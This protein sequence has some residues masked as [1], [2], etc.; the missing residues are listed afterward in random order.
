VE[1][2]NHIVKNANGQRLFAIFTFRHEFEFTWKNS[3]SL[4]DMRLGGLDRHESAQ[5]IESVFGQ[6]S[7][8]RKI[9]RTLIKQSDGVP[10]YLEEC[11]W[12]VLNQIQGTNSAA[13]MN[14]SFTVPDTLQDSLNA[15]LDMLGPARELAQLASV[16]GTY[17]TYSSIE[18]ISNLNGIDADSSMDT[19]LQAG[20]L[21]AVLQKDEDR[22]EFRH[23]M[24][25]DAAYQSLLKKTRQRYH[26]QIAEMFLADDP[27]INNRHP[28][29]IAFHYSCTEH[30]DTAVDLWIQAGKVAISNSTVREAISHLDQGIHLLKQLSPSPRTKEQELKLL[31]NL[32]V[33][34]TIQSGY[35]GNHITQ[36]YKRCSELA[37]EIGNGEQQWRALYGFWRCL[38]CLAEFASALRIS[39]KLKALCNFLDNRKLHMATLGIQAM[40]RMFSGRFSSAEKF[41][42][43]SVIHYDEVEDRNIGIRFGQDPYV[44][45]EGMGAVNK[46]IRGHKVPSR[47]RLEKSVQVARRIGHPY[48]I[49]EALRLAAVYEQ[50]SGDMDQLK[51]IAEEAIE[52]SEKFGFEGLLAASNIFLAFSDIANSR[53]PHAIPKIIENLDRYRE[54]YALLFYPYF[55]GLLA[56]SYLN[57]NLFEDAFTESNHVLQLI[58]KYGETWVQVP[59]MQIKAE[60]AARGK[61][62][63]GVEIIQ[64]Y[65]DAETLANKQEAILFRNQVIQ[66]RMDFG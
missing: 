7:L 36:L 3:E 39:V 19:L 12:H 40:T 66:S 47:L 6:V 54:K 25:Q 43:K 46:L 55:Q 48:T 56:K 62:A 53:N 37:D 42:Y 41:Y 16:F 44:T 64:W 58:D 60:S 49:V 18:K 51:D 4:I 23:V 8:P 59:M 38:V 45:I 20:M 11:S 30:L 29:L 22:Y 32:A 57:L 2:L 5:L 17:F 52:I 15:R 31:L 34:L 21:K 50:I 26:K 24:F 65:E 28:E 35:F 63:S 27:N 9:K 61:L 1:L 13:S 33:C 14:D 10:L